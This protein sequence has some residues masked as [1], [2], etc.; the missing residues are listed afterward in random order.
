GALP[1]GQPSSLVCPACGGVLNEVRDHRMLRFRCGLGHAYAPESLHGSQQLGVEAAL[2]A[3]LRALEEQSA[4]SRTLAA[5]ARD[6][7]HPRSAARYLER[8]DAAGEKAG[9]IRR[10]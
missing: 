1:P 3:A 4:L 2:W 8:A 7:R 5:R 6:G 9:L 10:A